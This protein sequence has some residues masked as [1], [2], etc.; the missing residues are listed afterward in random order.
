MRAKIFILILFLAI[1]LRTYK[2][3]KIPAGFHQDEVVNTY[4]GK[5]IIKNGIDLYGNKFPLLYFD[6]WGDYPPVLPMYFNGLGSLFFGD[7]VFGARIFPALFGALTVLCF[8]FLTYLLYPG[9]RIIIPLTFIGLL[10]FDYLK[11]KKI[12]KLLLI[13]LF[14]SVLLTLGISRTGWGQ[15]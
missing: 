11:N 9:F 1:G 6:K 4:V 10:I 15:S 7:T 8:F 3:D 12:S 5:F 2:L 13:S 14:F